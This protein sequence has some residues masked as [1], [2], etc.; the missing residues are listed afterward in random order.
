MIRSVPLCL[1]LDSAQIGQ[2]VKAAVN[3]IKIGD[4]REG[5]DEYDITARLPENE[6]QSL[7]DVLRLRV[8]DPKGQQEPLTERGQGG[9]DQR[10]VIHQTH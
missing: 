3:G 4:Y 10:S 5:E 8:P 1:G 6:R 7:Q 2:L 9:R